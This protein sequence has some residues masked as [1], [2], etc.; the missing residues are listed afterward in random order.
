MV[1]ACKNISVRHTFENNI[2]KCMVISVEQYIC[3]YNLPFLVNI[4]HCLV[5][6]DVYT[7]LVGHMKNTFYSI[8]APVRAA[9][10]CVA[11]SVLIWDTKGKNVQKAAKGAGTSCLLLL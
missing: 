6:L 5:I 3:G 10:N 9:P 11:G 4:L 2:G 1:S 7:E 8:Q